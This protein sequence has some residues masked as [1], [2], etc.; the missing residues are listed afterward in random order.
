MLFVLK[1]IAYSSMCIGTLLKY[2]TGCVKNLRFISISKLIL[3]FDESMAPWLNIVTSDN[4]ISSRGPNV[5]MPGNTWTTKRHN[6]FAM[7]HAAEHISLQ[8]NDSNGKILVLLSRIFFPIFYANNLKPI[9]TV[10]DSVENK[11][12]S[13]TN[14]L[15]YLRIFRKLFSFCLISP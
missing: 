3:D 7:A 6:P 9:D 4:Q 13:S 1:I 11:S 12:V 10:T 8:A 5:V 15:K 14:I 2:S